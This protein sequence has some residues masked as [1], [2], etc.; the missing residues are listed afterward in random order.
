MLK[1][2]KIFSLALM[3]SVLSGVAAAGGCFYGGHNEHREREER[4]ERAERVREHSEGQRD[5]DIHIDRR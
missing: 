4:R 1:N 2:N 3:L 5:I